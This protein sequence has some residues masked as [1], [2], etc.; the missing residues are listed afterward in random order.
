MNDLY[1]SPFS[2]DK[3]ADMSWSVKTEGDVYKH[4]DLNR[5]VFPALPADAS[6]K[7]GWF[8][9]IATQLASVDLSSTDLLTKWIL[10]CDDLLGSRNDVMS[11]L[12]YNSQGLH[13]LDR[14]V[15]KL[16]QLIG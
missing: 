13:L 14:T 5:V 3:G 12:H 15:G 9:S 1:G 11:A 10:L 16:I 7:R 8:A 6:G 2:D 4:R